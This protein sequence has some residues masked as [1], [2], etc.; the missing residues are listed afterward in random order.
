[1]KIINNI[2]KTLVYLSNTFFII[3]YIFLFICSR[4]L[5]N[6]DS[7]IFIALGEIIV[8][9]GYI[10]LTYLFYKNIKLNKKNELKIIVISIIT[11]IIETSILIYPYMCASGI[12]PEINFLWYCLPK[13][14]MLLS[15]NFNKSYMKKF[16]N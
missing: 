14:L 6:F 11:I 3:S 15:I 5:S 1:M 2:L 8:V 4:A 7:Y 12:F 16:K 13:A 9:L 10:Y